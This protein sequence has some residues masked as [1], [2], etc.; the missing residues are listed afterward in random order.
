MNSQMAAVNGVAQPVGIHQKGQHQ[1]RRR[2]SGTRRA[3]TC[4]KEYGQ[5]TRKDR[6]RYGRP[7]PVEPCRSATVGATP[8]QGVAHRRGKMMR[9]PGCRNYDVAG[10]APRPCAGGCTDP[11]PPR[12]NGTVH[13]KAQYR[14]VPG[15]GTT[16]SHQRVSRHRACHAAAVW[17]IAAGD[18]GRNGT[19]ACHSSQGRS[20]AD[21][22]GYGGQ[23]TR[24]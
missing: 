5:R 12:R 7:L 14:S 9:N 8:A 20:P 2:V 13:R 15:G 16:C 22:A 6:R 3:D 11:L 21:G 18:R 4:R 19:V 17:S 10:T 24:I 1:P 23:D